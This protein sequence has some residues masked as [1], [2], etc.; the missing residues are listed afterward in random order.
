METHR[1]NHSYPILAANF[2]ERKKEIRQQMGDFMSTACNTC[3][4]R[5]ISC[6]PQYTVKDKATV[7][8]FYC[9]TYAPNT[10][11]KFSVVQF[12]LNRQSSTAMEHFMKNGGF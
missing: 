1:I 4:S 3:L 12:Y 11:A 6:Q 8:M 10:R 5:K 7:R 2:F 9:E